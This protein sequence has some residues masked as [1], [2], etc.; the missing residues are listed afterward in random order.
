M[1]KSSS[2]KKPTYERIFTCDSS[3]DSKEIEMHTFDSTLEIWIFCQS[4]LL[5]E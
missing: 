3:L 5:Y 2:P 4:F 1:S